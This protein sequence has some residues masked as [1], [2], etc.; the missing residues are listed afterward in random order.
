MR[1]RRAAESVR[2][3][4]DSLT[5]AYPRSL[6]RAGELSRLLQDHRDRDAYDAR[7]GASEA[8]RVPVAVG[9]RSASLPPSPT[10]TQPRPRHRRP[11]GDRPIPR[12]AAVSVRQAVNGSW[13]D[14]PPTEPL[15]PS[16]RPRCTE[17]R[18]HPAVQIRPHR[19]TACIREW[20]RTNPD[21]GR[22]GGQEALRDLAELGSRRLRGRVASGFVDRRPRALDPRAA[23][24]TV[25]LR[26][27]E[28]TSDRP[29]AAARSPEQGPSEDDHR[30]T[31]QPAPR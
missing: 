18:A 9:L 6:R 13:A 30:G 23:R 1:Q 8:A 20:P 15:S 11:L 24:A 5:L 21:G 4:L 3:N 16:R 26:R 27:G 12:S 25:A 29:P 17:V 28:R 2:C 14:L 10:L 31:C 22:D 7:P 19:T